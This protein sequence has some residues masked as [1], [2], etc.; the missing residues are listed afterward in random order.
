MGLFDKFK[1]KEEVEQKVEK[2]EPLVV[3]MV[4][5]S[6]TFNF[7]GVEEID[8]RKMHK[9]R[10]EY[11]DKESNSFEIRNLYLDIIPGTDQNGNVIEGLDATEQYYRG[12]DHDTLRD[13]FDYQYT[14]KNS[15]KSDYYGYIWQN[16]NGEYTRRIADPEFE[17]LRNSK[18]KNDIA[19]N[20]QHHLASEE[21]YRRK[22][23]ENVAKLET[24]IKTSHA[25]D[26]SNS[27]FSR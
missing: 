6:T 3:D 13:F 19:E 8:G 26:L 18:Y 4:N 7:D 17:S 16:E 22:Q 21:E 1:K 14:S 9:L 27:Q 20:L 5:K 11:L 24:N 23:E 10:L 2:K 12:I 25:E 15:L